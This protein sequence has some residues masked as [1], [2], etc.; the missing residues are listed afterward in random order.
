VLI[1]E[2]YKDTDAA[3]WD[4]FIA[5]SRNA[6]FLFKRA[7][8]DYH[9]DRFD[10]YSLIVRLP[11]GDIVAVLPAHKR[12]LAL[13]SHL[14]LTYGGFA[15][16]PEM[17]TRR[18]L[19]VFGSL[20]EFLQKEGFSSLLYKTVPYIYHLTPTEED[21]YALHLC[22]AQW[23][24][25]SPTTVVVQSNR[26]PYQTRRARG[27]KRALK[28]NVMIRETDDYSSFWEILSRNLEEGHRAKAVH[29]V[30]EI[31]L[32][33]TRCPSSI[34]LFAAFENEDIVAG[35]V[36]YESARVAHAQYI[37]STPHGRDIGA[38]DLLFDTLLNDVFQH[39][40]YFDFGTSSEGQG[41]N[42]GL[43]EQKEGFGARVVTQDWF[44]VD[45]S[46]VC[47]DDLLSA[48]V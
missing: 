21:R 47:A 41:I 5:S 11:E 29:S 23:Y 17:K 28:Q 35:V 16:G 31:V 13:N 14:G 19:Q 3:A 18:M 30:D 45:L 46:R 2:R 25:S 27:V 26:L 48:I 33:K 43:I 1:I 10:D 34:R 6:P 42:G 38:L 36:I 24:L 40:M 32:L 20:V 8:M 22:K 15:V 7:Y 4:D 9:R 37:A 39:K 12:D 44:Q